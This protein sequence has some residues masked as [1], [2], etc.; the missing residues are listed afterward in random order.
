M[1]KMLDDLIICTRFLSSDGVTRSSRAGVTVRAS[2]G[3]VQSFVLDN[4]DMNVSLQM[5]HEHQ[6]GLF[7][8]LYHVFVGRFLKV[9]NATDFEVFRFHADAWPDFFDESD[10]PLCY[11]EEVHREKQA[12]RCLRYSIE[13]LGGLY[14]TNPT[15]VACV[16]LANPPAP[17]VPVDLVPERLIY[18]LKKPWLHHPGVARPGEELDALEEYLRLTKEPEPVR[19][20]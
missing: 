11:G 4:H 3:V 7:S 10:M 15:H 6:P 12:D 16:L 19:V 18:K 2:N 1:N 8:S 14:L 13:R 17:R 20:N 5:L 9:I